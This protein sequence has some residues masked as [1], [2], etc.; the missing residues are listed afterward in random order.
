LAGKGAGSGGVAVVAAAI[1]KAFV[2]FWFEPPVVFASPP[3]PVIAGLVS[4]APPGVL[5]APLSAIF[6]AGGAPAVTAAEQAD[7]IA[8]AL[9]AWTKTVMVI[10][11]P[12]TPPGPANPAV[13]LA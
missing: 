1:D 9:D 2:N 11:T 13:P 7:A 4:L 3:G 8:G 5:L 12:V 6:A 10:N